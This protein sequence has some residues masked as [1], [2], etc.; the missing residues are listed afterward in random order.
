MFI[1][2]RWFTL[3]LCVQIFFTHASFALSCVLLLL[4]V[5]L[6]I[7]TDLD[8]VVPLAN[9]ASIITM[10]TLGNLVCRVSQA[11]KASLGN[12]TNQARRVLSDFP[13]SS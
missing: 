8:N 1:G 7:L 12:L 13:A 2:W 5:N 10:V 4:C 3:Q 11:T 9:L 6:A